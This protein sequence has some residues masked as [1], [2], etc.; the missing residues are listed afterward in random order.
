MALLQWQGDKSFCLPD[1]ISFQIRIWATF[2]LPAMGNSLKR[3]TSPFF[4]HNKNTNHKNRPQVWRYVWEAPFFCISRTCEHFLSI[5]AQVISAAGLWRILPEWLAQCE[6]KFR[7][8]QKVSEGSWQLPD[9]VANILRLTISFHALCR[10]M[11]WKTVDNIAFC[12]G[13]HRGPIK[14]PQLWCFNLRGG[15]RG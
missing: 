15:E 12:S 4:L 9:L 14:D 1:N 6:G 5:K 7:R 11:I 3:P 10:W 8:W 2:V 13:A